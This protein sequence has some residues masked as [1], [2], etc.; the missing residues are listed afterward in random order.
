MYCSTRLRVCICLCINYVNIVTATDIFTEINTYYET[1][2]STY[3]LTQHNVARI[4]THLINVKHEQVH[5]A[6]THG[7]T[8]GQ[9]SYHLFVYGGQGVVRA[10]SFIFHCCITHSCT[11]CD[12]V[13]CMLLCRCGSVSNLKFLVL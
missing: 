6:Q 8:T 4:D 7:V 9:F 11:P 12:T 1:S 2:K 10:F 13:E 3:S 5:I